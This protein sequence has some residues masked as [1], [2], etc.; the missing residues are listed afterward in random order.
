MEKLRKLIQ[1]KLLLSTIAITLM[2]VALPLMTCLYVYQNWSH[3]TIAG[4]CAQQMSQLADTAADSFRDV[5]TRLRNTAIYLDFNTTLKTEYVSST[6]TVRK[7]VIQLMNGYQG[8]L[9]ASNMFFTYE[10]CERIYTSYGSI[11]IPFYRKDQGRTEILM[12]P[13][14][15]IFSTVMRI[16]SSARA[17]TILYTTDDTLEIIYPLRRG[18]ALLGFQLLWKDLFPVSGDHMQVF[19]TDRNDQLLA[20]TDKRM[21]Q[22]LEE[23]KTAYSFRDGDQITLEDT[24]YLVNTTAVEGYNVLCFSDESWFYMESH[25]SEQRFFLL[26]GAVVLLCSLLIVL[27]VY[28]VYRPVT[29]VQTALLPF[30][31]QNTRYRSEMESVEKGF[32]RLFS[33]YRNLEQSNL[34][35]RCAETVLALAENAGKVPESM[36]IG[37]G[38]HPLSG[39]MCF[40]ILRIHSRDGL[41]KQMV[42]TE[43]LNAMPDE[44]RVYTAPYHETKGFLLLTVSARDT[45]D[46]LK[47]LFRVFLSQRKEEYI[48]MGGIVKDPSELSD[49]YVQARAALSMY[50]RSEFDVPLFTQSP[51]EEP[52]S[53]L[54]LQDKISELFNAITSGEYTQSRASL[55]AIFSDICARSPLPVLACYDVVNVMLRASRQNR[56]IADVLDRTNGILNFDRVEFADSSDFVAFTN[57]LLELIFSAS[58]E[59]DDCFSDCCAMI[60]NLLLDPSLCPELIAEKLHLSLSVLQRIFREH[61]GISP[62]AYILTMRQDYAKKQL[63]STDITVRELGEQLGYSSASSFIRTFKREEGITPGEYRQKY[64]RDYSRLII[65]DTE[66]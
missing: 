11:Y 14:N 6:E 17:E 32:E 12:N 7:E 21:A 43:L 19:L 24:G 40:S 9:G 15:V 2:L 42:L 57:D 5:L 66:V 3:Q 1:K 31:D 33:Q 38:I 36:L 22:K 10:G 61:T 20:C 18:T 53:Q 25:T 45:V 26:Y 37:S 30:V 46:E 63:L 62:S 44:I 59:K 8:V 52:G 41:N 56:V 65:S 28:Y 51:A 34:R 39:Y 54:L 29:R 16:R 48:G 4:K 35:R 64:Q 47:A 27:F 49:S 55:D 60:Q 23:I 58:E 50:H 13:E